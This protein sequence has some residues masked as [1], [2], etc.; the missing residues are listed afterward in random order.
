MIRFTRTGP[1]SPLF[2][3]GTVLTAAGAVLYLFPVP[4]PLGFALG[5]LFLAAVAGVWVSAR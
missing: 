1:V 3:A 2:V 5:A 4:C